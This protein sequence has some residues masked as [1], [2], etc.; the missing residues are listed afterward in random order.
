[1]MQTS[2][3]QYRVRNTHSKRDKTSQRQQKRGKTAVETYMPSQAACD[4]F[5]HSGDQILA[6][7]S[8]SDRHEGA[9]AGHLA[10]RGYQNH[11]SYYPSYK[12][13]S[14][15]P[16]KHSYWNTQ[17][18]NQAYP[19]EG[20]YNFEHDDWNY[21]YGAEANAEDYDQYSQQPYSQHQSHQNTGWHSEFCDWADSNQQAYG[22]SI[23]P[24]EEIEGPEEEVSGN[25][26]E[27]EQ[28]SE[29]YTSWTS[30][31][32]YKLLQHH[33][34]HLQNQSTYVDCDGRTTETHHYR[35]PDGKIVTT[36]K[37]IK[38]HVTKQPYMES[39]RNTTVVQ[40]PSDEKV[41][42]VE[43]QKIRDYLDSLFNDRVAAISGNTLY[44]PGSM[45]FQVN[46]SEIE[47]D[48]C[49]EDAIGGV[50]MDQ[51]GSLLQ[52][53]QRRSQD[54]VIEEAEHD[55][56]LLKFITLIRR[57]QDLIFNPDQVERLVNEAND[58]HSGESTKPKLSQDQIAMIKVR[59][60]KKN[61]NTRE[62]EQER[63]SICLQVF[64]HE[65]QVK[66]LPCSHLYHP[67]CIDTWLG[68]NS[69]CPVCKHDTLQALSHVSPGGPLR[70]APLAT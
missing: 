28:S 7:F 64:E 51:F 41:D 13:Q 34:K 16:S 23:W 50:L 37:H 40:G 19:D 2:T 21:G 3:P 6:S 20:Y 55:S 42:E 15:T 18:E 11:S 62:C 36:R 26:E 65:E 69:H 1:M 33:P 47:E 67:V 22:N 48:Y 59:N 44:I 46:T 17:T 29:D 57:H 25:W 61:P 58:L 39:Y 60:F 70:K 32:P 12:R 24:I 9:C 56:V 49:Q 52:I 5:V 14:P 45:R 10:S 4:H 38:G 8:N 54:P 35:D 66:Q 53:A 27:S 68:R 31:L 63:C 30:Q 43:G